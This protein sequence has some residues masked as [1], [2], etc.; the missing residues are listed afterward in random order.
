[1]QILWWWASEIQ[2]LGL[3]QQSWLIFL[4]VKS[5]FFLGEEPTF[6]CGSPWSATLRLWKPHIWCWNPCVY[7]LA[8]SP[9]IWCWTNKERLWWTPQSNPQDVAAQ[10]QAAARAHLGHLGLSGGGCSWWLSR[11]DDVWPWGGYP[12]WQFWDFGNRDQNLGFWGTRFSEPRRK[13]MQ[14]QLQIPRFSVI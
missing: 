9:C 6:S 14:F 12:H 10:R 7:F 4:L 2:A 3:L 5:P 11:W 13:T 8:K 1:M